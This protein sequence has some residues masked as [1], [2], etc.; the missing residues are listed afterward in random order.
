MVA[1]EQAGAVLALTPHV[2]MHVTDCCAALEESV[3]PLYAVEHHIHTAL[4]ER[5][6]C[7]SRFMKGGG[8]TQVT[9]GGSSSFWHGPMSTMHNCWTRA[10]IRRA[11]GPWSKSNDSSTGAHS[12]RRRIQTG[13]H[14]CRRWWWVGSAL[15]SR[16]ET[17]RVRR[18]CCRQFEL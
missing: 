15:C 12:D 9:M 16:C 17:A 14:V 3:A 7:P 10:S 2:L 13:Y 1:E 8:R 18:P 4:R 6:P 11:T 5:N